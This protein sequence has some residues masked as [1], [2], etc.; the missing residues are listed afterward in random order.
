MAQRVVVE[1]TDDLDGSPADEKV[2]FGLDGVTY[3][4]DLTAAHAGELRDALATY[5]GFARKDPGPDGVDP[6][7][8]GMRQRP[9]VGRA[10]ITGDQRVRP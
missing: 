9:H 1:V 5:I 10:A 8:V 4:I 7:T 3:E 2:R 6:D